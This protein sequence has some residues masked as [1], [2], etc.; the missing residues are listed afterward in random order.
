MKKTICA[1]LVICMMAAMLA[2]CA[3]APAEK[4]A[5]QAPA[6]EAVEQ[7]AEEV[8][9][10]EETKPAED[11]VPVE[12]PEAPAVKCYN[13]AFVGSEENGVL[14][15][16]GIPFAKAPIG[17][18]RWKAPQN[19]EASNETF[20]ATSYGKVALQPYASSEPVSWDPENMS[21]DC[22]TLNIWTTGDTGKK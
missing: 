8:K 10:T 9:P 7:K 22:L 15:F 14:S 1:F 18:L 20:D 16:K 4:P 21:A 5:Q 2:G 11:A 13:G 3:S 12:E 17:E 6:A 19:V